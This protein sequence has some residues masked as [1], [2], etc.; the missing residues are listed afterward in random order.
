[1]TLE[2][3]GRAWNT[4]FFAPQ[5]PTP[6]ALYR[7]AYGMLVILDVLLLWP[8]WLTWFGPRG[9]QSIG[10]MHALAAGTRINLFATL[11]ETD[12][13]ANAIF[14]I[15]L[16]SAVFVTTGFLT[17]LSSA[18]VFVG[19]T[20]LHQ[21]N[22]FI[23]N[24]GDSLLR[25]TGFFLIFAPAGAAL[26]IDRLVRVWRGVEPV[27]VRPRAPWAQ[28]MIQ[29]EVAALY[30]SS[31]WAKAQGPHWLDGTAT[32]Y[33]FHLEQLR[34]FPLPSWFLTPAIVRL[35]TWLTLALEFSLGVLIWFKDLRYWILLSAL[36]LHAFIEYSMNI[37]L[38]EWIMCSAFITFVYPEDLTRVWQRVR[39]WVAAR[40]PAPMA[41]TYDSRDAKVRRTADVLRVLDIFGRLR[42]DEQ[43]TTDG[44]SGLSPKKTSPALVVAT[45]FGPRS[46]RSGFRYAVRALL[47]FWPLALVRGAWAH[48]K[49]G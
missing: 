21:R 28:R 10:T 38:F 40:L 5:R 31:F 46:G 42:F 23:T 32:Y 41:V 47:L 37:P 1:V 48:S 8:E 9:L 18:V 17:R 11:P 33:A 39:T 2:S 26:S 29:I 36:L 7:I 13:S 3:V 19:L 24:G 44:P 20:S 14:W 16:V 15:L 22:L 43:G 6:I 34:R 35:S 30:L 12:A 27:E 25:V 4:F 45:P 49:Q